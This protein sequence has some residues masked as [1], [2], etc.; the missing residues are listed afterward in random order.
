MFKM[1]IIF[2]LLIVQMRCLRL[3]TASQG[4]GAEPNVCLVGDAHVG[5]EKSFD[6]RFTKMAQQ[7]KQEKCTAVVL[8]GDLT[9][10]GTA[11]EL[12]R[13]KN[14]L[15]EY[16]DSRLIYATPGNHDL[17]SA[18]KKDKMIVAPLLNLT[19]NFLQV[20][21]NDH[22]TIEFGKTTV[23]ITNSEVLITKNPDLQERRQQLWTEL[24]QSLHMASKQDRNI[25]VICHRPLFLKERLEEATFKNWPLEERNRI[26][27]LL[28]SNTVTQFY[29]GHI[30]KVEKIKDGNVQINTITGTGPRQGTSQSHNFARIRFAD[31]GHASHQIMRIE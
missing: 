20:Y 11:D 15:T 23:L 19:Q 9:Q 25:V 28:P 5:Y 4:L 6:L 26:L 18:E 2:S 30:H 31:D 17:E 10:H 7:L 14:I 13:S 1:S 27:S 21:G 3:Q 24:E 16:I 8:L 29:A 22:H 12:E